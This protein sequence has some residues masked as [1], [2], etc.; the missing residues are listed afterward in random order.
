MKR[1]SVSL[2]IIMI[3]I[4]LFVCYHIYYQ[5]VDYG[6]SNLVRNYYDSKNIVKVEKINNEMH[7]KYLGI[8]KIPKIDL[9]KGFYNIDSKNNNIDK[10]VTILKESTLPNPNGSIIYLIAHSG[11]GYHAFFKDIDK[12]TLDDTIYLDINNNSYQYI[13]NDIYEMDKNGKIT[14]NHNI[15]DNYLVLTTCSNNKNKQLVIVSKL[16]NKI[17]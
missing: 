13:I 16:V 1:K 5:F 17:I 3:S 8:I 2:I 10:N 9:E 4:S 6:S 11:T 12:L 14:V 15:H 7:E